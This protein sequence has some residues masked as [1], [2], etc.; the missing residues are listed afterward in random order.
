MNENQYEIF[1][2]NLP[3]LEKKLKRIEKK[4]KK[5]GCEFSYKI[6][7][8][9]YREIK[10]DDNSGVIPFARKRTVKFIVI[11][12]YGKVI[13]NGWRFI[14][15][16]EHTN[17]GNIIRQIDSIVEVPGKYQNAPSICEHCKVQRRRNNTYIVLNNETNEFKQVGKSCLKEFTGGLSASDVSNYYSYFDSIIEAKEING[18]SRSY[19][20]NKIEMLHYIAECV[21][22]YGYCKSDSEYSTASRAF[23]YYQFDNDLITNKD[24]RDFTEKELL[25]VGFNKNSDEVKEMTNKALNW[26]LNNED[27]N[28]YINNLKVVCSLEYVNYKHFGILSSLFIAYSKAIGIELARKEK[29]DT[30]SLSNY[31]GTIK[32]KIKVNITSFELVTSWET[33]FGISYLYKMTDENKNILIWVT[34]KRLLCE[35][36]KVIAGTIKAHYEYKNV[37]QTVLTRCK[38]FEE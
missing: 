29:A 21:N 17:N 18:S 8:E 19:C 13:F 38:V 11:E 1:E 37:K 34:S 35:T 25:R 12:A 23:G 6:I 14:A 10:I 33:Q 2:D 4:C 36:I 15:S 9:V 16:I 28:N 20:Y 3:A 5:F 7:R 24:T 22:K 30:E 32:E 26:I 31:I 27:T